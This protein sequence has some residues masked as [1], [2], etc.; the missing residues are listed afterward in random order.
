MKN[1]MV[2]GAALALY[3]T[4]HSIGY[5]EEAIRKY[6][7]HLYLCLEKVNKSNKTFPL[8]AF[9]LIISY[10]YRKDSM[11]DIINC[12]GLRCSA[13][14]GLDK[15]YL[16]H[17][18]GV[19][20]LISSCYNYESL[21]LDNANLSEVNPHI[22]TMGARLEK[23]VL[24]HNQIKLSYPA[25]SKPI[26]N[27]GDLTKLA[28]L[29]L[30]SNNITS[31][32]EYVYKLE[33]LWRLDLSS[34]DLESLDP[35][36][37]PIAPIVIT[38]KVK[39]S[40]FSRLFKK[41]K[42]VEAKPLVDSPRR[43]YDLSDLKNMEM[44]NLNNNQLTELP[45]SIGRLKE[46][47]ELSADANQLTELPDLSNSNKLERLCIKFNNITV[48]PTLSFSIR[49]LNLAFNQIELLPNINHLVNAEEIYLNNNC[50]KLLPNINNL[51]NLKVLH[52]H[53]NKLT[54]SPNVDG[55]TEL[56]VLRLER[57]PI[58]QDSQS[59]AAQSECDN[60]N[61]TKDSQEDESHGN[62][63]REEAYS[64]PDSV[65]SEWV[66]PESPLSQPSD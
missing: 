17:V 49:I 33:N 31:L 64:R 18:V 38:K 28:E 42:K 62:S 65:G 45:Q 29:D 19:M 48:F 59:S 13:Q 32:P 61:S 15:L 43:S 23:L 53:V 58:V 46:L 9:D 20:Q 27:V 5:Y 10:V 8:D 36:L 2:Y 26:P 52:L 1:F 21:Y 41:N 7:N 35:V 47:R 44:L 66:L 24:S 56:K 63:L 51:S 4:A 40:F 6:D 34:N 12:V 55:L 14:S 50:I 11:G 37:A 30:G 57:N 16:N 22:C 3:N 60:Q 54:K 25:N 39:E